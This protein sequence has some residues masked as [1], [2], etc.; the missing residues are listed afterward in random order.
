MKELSEYNL[1]TDPFENFTLWLSQAE[2]NKID[3]FN[4]FTLA[5]IHSD[6]GP[7]A[8]TV[9]YK[10]LFQ[11]NICF[12][13]SYEG[14]KAKQMEQNSIVSGVFYWHE[15]GKQIR[16]RGKVN[17]LSDKQNEAYFKS[18]AKESQ[19]AALSSNQSEPIA[20]KQA[21]LDKYQK[22][23]K[24][25]AN[26]QIPTPDKWGGYAIQV[27]EFEFFL[28]DEHRLNDRFHFSRNEKG[29]WESCRLQ[30]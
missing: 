30:P 18:R 26:S 15:L 4:A 29:K 14:T 3:N 5:S 27:S 8:R 24:D 9:L 19:L 11:E 10:G 25:Y 17:K 7:D 28:H 13:T 20:N 16:F 23:E 6:G 22:L 2:K 1:S 21:L 12:Y